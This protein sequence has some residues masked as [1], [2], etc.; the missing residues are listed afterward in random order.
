MLAPIESILRTSYTVTRKLVW[1][2]Y[3]RA[4]QMFG[5]DV[6]ELWMFYADLKTLK[7]IVFIWMQMCL[8]HVIFGISILDLVG[9]FFFFLSP[10]EQVIIFFIHF[11]WVPHWRTSVAPTVLVGDWPQLTPL[12]WDASMGV[13]A[14]TSDDLLESAM[15]TCVRMWL[16]FLRG[17]GVYRECTIFCST[18]FY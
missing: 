3:A 12:L 6:T 14:R 10:G 16:Q 8:Y 5:F 11:C 2:L 15:C 18:D 1:D 13:L 7:C 17:I 4:K 9:S